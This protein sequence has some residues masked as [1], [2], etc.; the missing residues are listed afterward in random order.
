[1]LN[2]R[3]F[4]AASAAVGATVPALAA[5]TAPTAATARFNGA[6]PKAVMDALV[7]LRGS[8]DGRIAF[9]WMRGTR[10]GVVGTTVTPFFENL[11]ASWHRFVRQPDGN[12]KVSMV[13]LSYYVD[14]STGKLL[15]KWRN[16]LTGEMNDLEHIHFGPV[17]TTLTPQGITPPEKSRGAQLKVKTKIGV[18][19]QHNDGIWLQEDV[20]ATIIPSATGSKPYQGNDIATYQGSVRQLLDPSSPSADATMH[21]QSVTDWRTWMKMGDIKG[22]LMARAAG[23]KVW[24]ASDLPQETLAAARRMHPAIISDPVAALDGTQPDGS[25]R[26]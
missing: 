22:T 6:D 7:K 18:I 14:L 13:E 12:Y 1:M 24:N 9:W 5:T 4:I 25:F 15:D 16:P 8:Q 21:Y 10:Y 19:A 2:R 26:R 20:S 11:V 3:N 17:T 23:G